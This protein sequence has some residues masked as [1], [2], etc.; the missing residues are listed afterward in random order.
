MKDTGKDAASEEIDRISISSRSPVHI[1]EILGLIDR[2]MA[3]GVKRM[4]FAEA[5]D[6]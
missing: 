5:P 3:A 4:A 6:A 2:V 1:N